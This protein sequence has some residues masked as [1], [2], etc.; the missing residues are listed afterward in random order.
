MSDITSGGGLYK[1][2]SEN[3][4]KAIEQG[5]KVADLD[6]ALQRKNEAIIASSQNVAKNLDAQTVA[7][8]DAATTVER[9]AA[10]TRSANL[11]RDAETLSLKTNTAEQLASVKAMAEAVRVREALAS[12]GRAAPARVGGAAPEAAGGG[13]GGGGEAGKSIFGATNP[14]Q[15]AVTSELRDAVKGIQDSTRSTR[16][17]TDAV[18]KAVGAPLSAVE[19][20]QQAAAGLQGPA[21]AN[22]GL[23]SVELAAAARTVENTV[24]G[25]LVQQL[26]VGLRNLLTRT[27]ASQQ[28]SVRVNAAQQATAA[29]E[30]ARVQQRTARAGLSALTPAQVA[31]LAGNQRSVEQAAGANNLRSVAILPGTGAGMTRFLPGGPGGGFIGG[32]PPRPPSTPGFSGGFDDEAWRRARIE[33][34]ALADQIA[35]VREG[36]A[37]AEAQA[38]RMNSAI[39]GQRN[40]T[41][42]AAIEFGTLS[43]NLRRHGALTSEFIAA[44]ARGET[45]LKEL[46][47]QTTVTIGKF[48]GWTL[49]ATAVFTVFDAFK[50]LTQGAKET[51][52]VIANLQRFIP[53]IDTS[54][55]AAQIRQLSADTN[56][57]V[58]EVGD[59]AGQFARVFKNQDDVFTAA[60]TSIL[61]TK[62]DNISAADSF[63]F[64]TAI[65][66]GFKLE[67][68]DLPGI[69]DEINAAQREFGAPVAQTLPGIARAAGGF[70]LGGGTDPQF[71]ESMIST[72]VRSTGAQ[73]AN[74]GIAISRSATR[75]VQTAKSQATLARYGVDP[76]QGYQDII[77]GVFS[78]IRS[79]QLDRT[80]INQLAQA[81]GGPAFGGRYFAGLFTNPDLFN[82]I[83]KGTSLSTPGVRGSAETE[84]QKVLHKIGEQTH[85]IA[86]QLANLGSE[87]GEAGALAPVQVLLAAL[88]NILK[89]GGG[90]V[91]VFNELPTILQYAVGGITTFAIILKGIQ[92][93]GLGDAIAKQFPG[94]S[95]VDN[96]DR[97]LSRLTVRGLRDQQ[98]EA[99]N[100]AEG[101]ARSSVRQNIEAE[102]AQHR[103]QRF[104][105]GGTGHGPGQEKIDKLA[106]TDERR[107]NW[108]LR[109][110]A[111]EQEM[112]K[113][114]L[115]A[116]GAAEKVLAA[117]EVAATTEREIAAVDGMR[118]DALRRHLVANAIDVPGSFATPSSAP[119]SRH[120]DIAGFKDGLDSRGLPLYGPFTREQ[121]EIHDAAERGM[122]VRGARIEDAVNR[123]T[124]KA[125]VLMAGGLPSVG[126][127]TQQQ[128]A[129]ADLTGAGP[130]NVTARL[131]SGLDDYGRSAAAALK[132]AKEIEAIQQR[133]ANLP[134]GSEGHRAVLTTH[135]DA[136]SETHAA[137]EQ[138][139]AGHLNAVRQLQDQR[140]GYSGFRQRFTRAGGSILDTL[141][142]QVD[143]GQVSGFSGP[144]MQRSNSMMRLQS[145]YAR[146]NF[147]GTIRAQADRIRKWGV[148]SQGLRQLAEGDSRVARA[149]G[150]MTNSYTG[151]GVLTAV[152]KGANLTARAAS[153]F[154]GLL[155]RSGGGFKALGA[156]MRGILAG[157]G[158]L[159]AG[160]AALTLWFTVLKPAL[161]ES[162]KKGD[163]FEAAASHVAMSPGAR[164]EQNRKAAQQATRQPTAI[165]RFISGDVKLPGFIRSLRTQY[166][167]V[168]DISDAVSGVWKGYLHARGVETPDEKITRERQQ[169]LNDIAS[170]NKQ[171]ATQQRALSSGR[172]ASDLY[173]DQISNQ[174][175]RDVSDYRKGYL[176]IGELGRRMQNLL[177]DLKNSSHISPI[178]GEAM[179]QEILA[180][181]AVAARGVKGYG[182][183]LKTMSNK[184]LQ[185][186][187]ARAS[188]DLQS[189]GG[190]ALG[191][192]LGAHSR[193]QKL[194]SE[195]AFRGFTG[196]QG[197]VDAWAQAEKSL[198]DAVN[199][200][201]DQD[202]QTSLT[203]ATTARQRRQAYSRAVH[204]ASHTDV[205]KGAQ[206]AY[207][208]VVGQESRAR[209]TLAQDIRRR[210]VE[211]DRE[212]RG[213]A[214]QR[215]GDPLRRGLGKNI[216]ESSP[217]DTQGVKAS[218]ATAKELEIAVQKDRQN[219]EQIITNR[220]TAKKV[221]HDA[222]R[223]QGAKV[224]QIQQQAA[225][226]QV[227]L[228][229]AEGDL[230]TSKINPTNT[231]A[232]GRQALATA[233]KVLHSMRASGQFSTKDLIEAEAAVNQAKWQIGQQVKDDA[234]AIRGL[235]F[236]IQSARDSGDPRAQARDMI[237][238][239]KDALAHAKTRKDRLQAQLDLI[240]AQND[241]EKALQDYTQSR[242]E[243][244]ESLTIDPLKGDRLQI[245]AAR[246]A[247]KGTK[248]AD[249]LRALAA[250]HKTKQQYLQDKVQGREDTID[251]EL[252]MEKITT[253]EAIRDLQNLLKVRNMGKAKRREIQQRIHDL[254]Q[255]AD[256]QASGFDLD[257]GSIKMP[258][259]YDVRRAY[260]PLKAAVHQAHDM[261]HATAMAAAR[262]LGT[263]G[264]SSASIV[265][266][267]TVIV[268]VHD[269]ASAAHVYT[270][271]DR[272]LKTHVGAKVRSARPT[273][274]RG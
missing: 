185:Q 5:Q 162:K 219:L 189:F 115:A 174:A 43:N 161:E 55:A 150:V 124:L 120:L 184:R 230:A 87:L 126:P 249:R 53:D 47:Y 78:A 95:F 64:F 56:T 195:L 63:R 54:K 108:Y 274:L 109:R 159:D 244:L 74:V 36:E 268:N 27:V 240:N 112:L 261:S 152:D 146:Q 204:A 270:A 252:N 46:A 102:V 32:G 34:A 29:R 242:F 167:G 271:I 100:A 266:Q 154:S 143:P 98:S 80:Q 220:Q 153:S 69:L 99:F 26:D 131:K 265:N 1:G 214:A 213:Q 192:G 68:K 116:Q 20:V 156:S 212:R 77:K 119:L 201:I 76:N 121:Q 66:Q 48:A 229:R 81:V 227:D 164:A 17:A 199:S 82:Q 129:Y 233:R 19:R 194:T 187:V 59:A 3:F 235:K 85:S 177:R 237:A 217:F 118:G 173:T 191:G 223:D 92:R 196:D 37:R 39:G 4:K 165:D 145:I 262:D 65:I 207:D 123:Q 72:I 175:K 231:A 181:E 246:A 232:I 111:L 267:P 245:Q 18:R 160:L 148:E 205:Q 23:Q 24:R 14:E 203:L 58:T 41:R 256:Q 105:G 197:Q 79:K 253:D 89:I 138:E 157:L 176:S 250:V 70:K 224:R 179:R 209:D 42:N 247:V 215:G 144:G 97:R 94:L 6:A 75:F 22:R 52:N 103:Y 210:N 62:L 132:T 208:R 151:R 218:G 135:L 13:G 269:K 35:R 60:R 234:A 137:L 273:R 93:F 117:K 222:N 114:E 106:A 9:L 136:L 206:N 15:V 31:V 83:N 50:H 183:I 45:T 155:S 8:N 211:R 238:K 171:V 169:A 216:L 21:G 28:E 40:A 139:A 225:Q 172:T 12:L 71:L 10:S 257:V 44:A 110:E 200:Q 96:P 202:L 101:Y 258:T 147:A 193:I 7:I 91:G 133:L 104:I 140:S 149:L 251:F 113:A 182:D 61:A 180:L 239:A 166:G 264:G 51:Q 57:S 128:Q 170:R 67:A 25:P 198:T 122:S 73:G 134:A 49:A 38:L 84:L 226:E 130:H 88:T 178:A 86:V 168:G 263:S 243:Y 272:A 248:G 11:T 107:V 259:A 236:D 127:Y 30:A 260:A 142:G 33:A 16:A 158:P 141:A 190:T 255:Q 163:D 90:I 228:I 188:R 241:S 254:K 186:E 221:L 125:R 2:A